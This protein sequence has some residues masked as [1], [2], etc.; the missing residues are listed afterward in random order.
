MSVESDSESHNGKT[1]SAAHLA[2]HVEPTSEFF[3]IGIYVVAPRLCKD[4]DTVTAE[5]GL[6]PRVILMRSILVFWCWCQISCVTKIGRTV[7][8]AGHGIFVIDRN[9]F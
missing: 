8:A 9:H 5:A 2:V 4:P 7:L 6:A 1:K 3:L